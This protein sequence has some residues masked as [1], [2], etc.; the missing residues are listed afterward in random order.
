MRSR[1]CAYA[2]NLVDY[3]VETTHPK[4]P[5]YEPDTDAW[6]QELREFH[7]S[8]KFEGLDILEFVDGDK[9][10]YVAFNAKLKQQGRDASF[11]E[12]SKFVKEADRWL[13]RSGEPT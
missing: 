7:E 2:L 4:H 8:T 10:A 6:K 9:E 5:Q 3:L 1:Y 11:C 13:Y 12:R